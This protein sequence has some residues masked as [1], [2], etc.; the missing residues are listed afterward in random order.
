MRAGGLVDA[1]LLIASRLSLTTITC[2][3]SP[4]TVGCAARYSAAAIAS[5]ARSRGEAVGGVGEAASGYLL[6]LAVEGAACA[7]C[8]LC[9]LRF[10]LEG[11]ACIGYKVLLDPLGGRAR[12]LLLRGLPYCEAARA[13]MQGGLPG[14]LP[15]R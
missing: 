1:V 11:A 12:V 7:C 6:S 15:R 2:R 3:Q 14:L 13:R 4:R 9:C 8:C 10:C 5:V